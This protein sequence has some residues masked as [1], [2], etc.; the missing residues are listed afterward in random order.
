MRSHPAGLCNSCRFCRLITNQRGSVFTLCLLS[1]VD[2]RFDKYP[3]LPVLDCS[4]FEQIDPGA[5]IK[6]IQTEI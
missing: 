3:R 5:S 2:K 6:S 1:R 4:G